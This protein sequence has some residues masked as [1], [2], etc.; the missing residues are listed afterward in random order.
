MIQKKI[1]SSPTKTPT[2][3][4]TGLKSVAKE[5]LTEVEVDSILD[6]TVGQTC[7][8]IEIYQTL[9]GNAEILAKYVLESQ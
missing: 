7:V 5:I 9:L 1:G 4:G 2:L 8:S 6:D 3:S